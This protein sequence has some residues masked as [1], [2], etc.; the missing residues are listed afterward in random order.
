MKKTS[1]KKKLMVTLSA[2]FVIIL[3]LVITFSTLLINKTLTESSESTMNN[4]IENVASITNEKLQA[5]LVM[6]QAIANNEM[7]S[8]MSIPME[9]KQEV[10]DSYIKYFGLRSIGI[11][12]ASGTLISTDGYR[13][14]VSTKDYYQNLLS[15]K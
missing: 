8:N 13:G 9:E 2:F 12:D 15:G 14:D 11:M 1:I 3:G 10:L 7:I 5:K 4:M 6:T